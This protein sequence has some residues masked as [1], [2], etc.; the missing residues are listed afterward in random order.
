MGYYQAQGRCS[1][2]IGRAS[3]PVKS[4]VLAVRMDERRPFHIKAGGSPWESS[5]TGSFLM[6]Q[7]DIPHSGN[8]IIVLLYKELEGLCGGEGPGQ[9]IPTCVTCTSVTTS[10]VTSQ[11]H[12]KLGADGRPAS[13]QRLAWGISPF[14]CLASCQLEAAAYTGVARI[15]SILGFFCVRSAQQRQMGIA[16]VLMLSPSY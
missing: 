5:R 2:V 13:L 3:S 9:A 4:L 7:S 15:V 14:N 8:D 16:T 1:L 11:Y 6:T 12:N 10:K